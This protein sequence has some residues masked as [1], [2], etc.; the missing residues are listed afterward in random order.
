MIIAKITGGLG[1]Q[2]F[3]Y[4][5]GRQLAETHQTLLKLYL[6]SFESDYRKYALHCFQIQTHLATPEEIEDVQ[7]TYGAVEKLMLKITSLFAWRNYDDFYHQC[8]VQKH[9]K[10]YWGEA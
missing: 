6:S 7:E 3:Q 9:E 1:N 4:A 2:M 8:S 10:R 5:L